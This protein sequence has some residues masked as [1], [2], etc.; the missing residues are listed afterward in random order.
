MTTTLLNCEVLLSQEIGDYWEGTSTSATSS[1][2][3]VDTSLLAKTDNWI[4]DFSYDMLTSGSYNEEERKISTSSS[5]STGSLTVLAHGGSIASG[6]TY[7]VHRLF[8]P[9]EKRRALISATKEIFGEC[10]DMVW[11]ESLVSGNWLR[12][13]SFERWTT[14]TD[15]TDWSESV[16]VP[17]QTATNGLFKH[18]GYS[19]CLAGTAGTLTQG[20]TENSDLR[21]LAGKTVS[22]TLQG[23]CNVGSCLRIAVYDGSTQT[24]SD[25]H[26]GGTDWTP[27]TDPLKVQATINSTPTEVTFKVCHDDANGTSYVDDGRVISGYRNRTYSGHLGLAQNEPNEIFIEP[28]QYSR[29]EPWISIHDWEVDEDGYLY[30]PTSVSNDYRLRVVGKQYLD[31]ISSGTVSTSWSATINLNEPQTRILTAQA[32]VYLYTWMSMPNYESGTRE[33]YQEMVGF[34]KQEVKERKAKFGMPSLPVTT[35]W[36]FE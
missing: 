9:S 21:Q 24:F 29:E 4:T 16:I 12:D 13:G 33:D 17:A 25:Y 3:I 28:A 7:R 11:N 5:V 22:F 32:A 26:E 14:G 6:V 36:G 10:Y 23:H 34:W 8:E 31:F 35:S 1:V 20:Y 18:G 19:A 15:L 30:L 27:D 2:T